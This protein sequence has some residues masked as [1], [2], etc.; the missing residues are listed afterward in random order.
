MKMTS[1][2]KTEITIETQRTF[3][4][5]RRPNF[6]NTFCTGCAALSNFAS[7][8]DAAQLTGGSAREIYRA[9]EIGQLHFIETDERQ[10]QV[11]LNSL[12]PVASAESI[13][14]PSNWIANV[15]FQ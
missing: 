1:K 13:V 8:E 15:D 6:T 14:P 11:C 3:I 12:L 4:V 2:S 7:P 10:M 5:R 9:I